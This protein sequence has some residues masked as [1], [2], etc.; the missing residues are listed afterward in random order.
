ME[1]TKTNYNGPVIYI[2]TNPA[3]PELVKIGYT[4]N[5]DERLKKLNNNEGLPYSFRL[6]AY[7]KVNKSLSDIKLHN[8]IDKLNPQLRTIENINGRE[9]KREFYAMSAEE[10][11]DILDAIAQING[12]EAN[13]VRCDKTKQQ[14]MEENLAN[15]IKEYSED[16]FTKNYPFIS[17]VYEMLKTEILKLKDVYIEPKKKYIAFKHQTNVCDVV[18]R[19]DRVVVF[20]NLPIGS[21]DDPKSLCEDVTDKGHWGNGDYFIS[22]YNDDEKASAIAYAITLIKQ[23]YEVN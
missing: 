6:Y 4:T 20:I 3:F 21:L 9:R 12:L 17:N 5:V 11:Y 13:L 10:A 14:E 2:L 15:E 22:I 1:Y 23:S 18:F 19:K 8:I 16:M 7:Y